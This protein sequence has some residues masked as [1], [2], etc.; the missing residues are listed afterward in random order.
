MALH[1]A[2]PVEALG[3]MSARPQKITLAE[4]R[5]SGVRGLLRS[6]ALI[7]IAATT[8][9]SVAIVGPMIFGCPISSR[10]LSA[11]IAAQGH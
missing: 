2:C 1:S 3:R 9:R 4:M 7:I 5:S 6:I 11:A 8:S 10:G